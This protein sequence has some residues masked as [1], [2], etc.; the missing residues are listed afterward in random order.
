[1]ACK[2]KLEQLFPS[3]FHY[4]KTFL[5]DMPTAELF[6]DLYWTFP[7][8]KFILTDRPSLA[9]AKSRKKHHGGH[10]TFAPIEEPCGYYIDDFTD[11]SNARLFQYHNDLVRCIVPKERLFEMNVWDDAAEQLQ[12]L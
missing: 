9:W 10:S 12:N 4:D 6:L 7:D 1:M 3:T 8:S 11:K 2:N 5:I